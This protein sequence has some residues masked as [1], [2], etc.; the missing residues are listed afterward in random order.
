MKRIAEHHK[1]DMEKRTKA[2]QELFRKHNYNP[3]SGC[4]P[5]VIQL[6]IFIGLYRALS[7]DIELRGTPL[8]PGISW[9]SNLAAPDQLFYWEP[10]LPAFLVS[11][12]GWLGPYFNILPLITI[13]FFIIHQ[14]LFT[15]P[16]T[17]EQSAMQQKMMKFMM[18]FMGFLFFRVA[19]GLCLYIIASSAWGVA[20]RLLL[21]KSKP[22]DGSA[23]VP[24]ANLPSSREP[25]SSSNGSS[26]K[27][28]GRKRNAKGKKR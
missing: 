23:P 22:V 24:S 26:K 25:R 27:S 11:L 7:V 1:G 4:L 14:K 28:T 21:P 3:L 15:P 20:E 10:F 17:D 19:S 8:I 18:I 2:Q 12:T 6:P 5:M 13:A 16:A 9:C